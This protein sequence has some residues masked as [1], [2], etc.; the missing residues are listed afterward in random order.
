MYEPN[1][2]ITVYECNAYREADKD[3]VVGGYR[4]PKRTVLSM[5]P[6]ALQLSPHNF[7][8]PGKFWPGRWL[9][10]SDTSEV[11]DPGGH[12]LVSSGACKLF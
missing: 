1:L 9:K 7:I 12:T 6:Y 3:M 11:I 10:A 8:A 5:P 2:L 4:V